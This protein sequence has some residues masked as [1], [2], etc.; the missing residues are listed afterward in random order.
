MIHRRSLFVRLLVPALVVLT[1]GCLAV[2]LAR[3]NGGAEANQTQRASAVTHIPINA[4][5]GAARFRNLSFQPEVAKFARRVG[6]RFI[7]SEASVSI[8]ELS[9]GDQQFPVRI[10]RRQHKEGEDLEIHAVDRIS[11]LTWT[12]VDGPKTNNGRA[13]GVDRTIIERVLLDSPDQFVLAQLRGASYQTIAKNLRPDDAG[14]GYEG[15]LWTVMR[16]ADPETDAEKKPSSPWRLY[17]INSRTGLIDKIVSDVA[18]ERIEAKLSGWTIDSAEVI[19]TVITWTK[20]DQ[21]IM[22]LKVN[23]FSRPTQR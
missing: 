19:P 13:T 6:Q 12:K 11:P 3:K 10:T 14:D 18:G 8:G 20:G 22:E 21:R 9:A 23:T 2:L 5:E 15:P 4:K 16:V 17:Y 7:A 1:A